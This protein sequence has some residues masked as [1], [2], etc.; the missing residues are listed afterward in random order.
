M[1]DLQTLKAQL[2]QL[3]TISDIAELQAELN[4]LPGLI[5]LKQKTDGDYLVAYENLQ[6][7]KN[8]FHKRVPLEQRIRTMQADLAEQA[9]QHSLAVKAKIKSDF[10]DKYAMYKQNCTRLLNDYMELRNLGRLNPSLNF[11]E[12][13]ESQLHLPAIHPQGDI[14]TTAGSLLR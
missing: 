7:M 6:K 5:I 1:N 13:S 8:D 4:D 14:G 2:A 11:D 3:P 9:H 10:A 12:L